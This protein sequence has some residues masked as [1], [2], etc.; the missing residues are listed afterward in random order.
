MSRSTTTRWRAFLA[1]GTLGVSLAACGGDAEVSEPG[2][3]PAPADSPVAT[4]GAEAGV[5]TEP[6]AEEVTEETDTAT[7][8][9][10]DTATDEATETVTE[11][12]AEEASDT[13]ESTEAAASPAGGEEIAVD[14]LLERLKSP[15]EEQLSSFEMA[16]DMSAQGQELAMAGAVDMGGETPEMNITM[17]ITGLGSMEMILVD[18]AAYLALPGVTEEGQY[19]EVPADQLGQFGAGDLT[20][21][22]DLGATWDGWDAG[23]QRAT[24]L[25]SE[26][27]DGEP[28]DHYQ[29]V[30]DAAAAAEAMGQPDVAG[31]P[32][33][34]TYD[35]W[36]DEDD[37]MRQMSFE[38]EGEVL[39]MTM[40]NWGGDVEVQAPDPSSIVE[41]PGFS[42]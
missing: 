23:A 13:E 5:E 27:V 28:M 21:S 11:E 34:L 16:M 35:V 38:V 30:V 40:D 14:E 7:A 29:I 12:G 20:S 42:G 6:A 33:E 1:A 26:D 32:A 39:E 15:G 8:E 25:G 41:V 18:G 2:D 4:E 22:V 3:A 31:M 37:F 17:D 24:F 10:I 19:V 9:G 36:V